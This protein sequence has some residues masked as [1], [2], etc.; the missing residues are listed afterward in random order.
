MSVVVALRSP[1]AG[2]ASLAAFLRRVKLVKDLLITSN[3]GSS[4]GIVRLQSQTFI[5]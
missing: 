4:R 5:A 3:F 2:D 1:P